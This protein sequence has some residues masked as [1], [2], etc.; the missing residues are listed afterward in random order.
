MFFHI[1]K[2]IYYST[3]HFIRGIGA[4]TRF[5]H[6]VHSINGSLKSSRTIV[7]LTKERTQK[8]AFDQKV[9]LG[10][11]SKRAC[12]KLPMTLTSVT[13]KNSTFECS[14]CEELVFNEQ[15]LAWHLMTHPS[16]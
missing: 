6:I 8:R 4:H 3:A 13:R 5:F 14:V 11:C 2:N 16:N 12:Q 9:I 10:N 15:S 1:K 7:K